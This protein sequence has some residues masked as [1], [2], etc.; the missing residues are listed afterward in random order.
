MENAVRAN[1][2]RPRYMGRVL[3][4]ARNYTYNERS[5][6]RMS[7]FSSQ[8]RP[9]LNGNTEGWY[10]IN[11]D[12]MESGALRGRPLQNMRH[13]VLFRSMWYSISISVITDLQRNENK[14]LN[15]VLSESHDWCSALVS[16]SS[17]NP[18]K[19]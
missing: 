11:I 15:A 16:I 1:Q 9:P 17:E 14:Y 7:Q 6:Q 3:Y 5:T 18:W 19:T 2:L 10:E 13:C 4:F 8:L 12:G